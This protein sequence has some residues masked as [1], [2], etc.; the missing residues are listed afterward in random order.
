[1]ESHLKVPR[2]PSLKPLGMTRCIHHGPTGLST[3]T[4]MFYQLL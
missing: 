3:V 2:A 1:M 4:G